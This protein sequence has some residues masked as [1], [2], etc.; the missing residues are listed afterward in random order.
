MPH[1]E[2]DGFTIVNPAIHSMRR[3][4][5]RSTVFAEGK[6]GTRCLLAVPAVADTAR[7]L[8]D[9]LADEGF[10]T[11]S[12]ITVQAIAFD[13]SPGG[14]WKVPWHQ[15]LMFPFAGKVTHPA[16]DLPCIKDGVHFARPPLGVL[17]GLLAVR[18]HLDDCPENNGPLRISPGTHRLGILPSDRIAHTVADHGSHTCTAAEGEALLMRPLALHASSQATQAKHRRVLHFVF[19]SGAPIAERWAQSV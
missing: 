15:D 11:E 10:L 5:L 3:D 14:N 13:K 9:A 16:Y 8:R 2:N 6:A 1:L 18:L 17:E 19:Y 4:V 7:E 12:S